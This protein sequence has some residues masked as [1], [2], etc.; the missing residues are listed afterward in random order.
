MRDMAMLP[1]FVRANL[2]SALQNTPTVLEALTASVPLGSPIW[3]I[4]PDPQRF[5]LREVLAHLA[6]WEE[7]FQNRI[8]RIRDE[9]LPKLPD[10]D[11]DEFAQQHHYA[12]SDP[13][14]QRDL[15]AKRRQATV[16]IVKGL[17]NRAW[18]RKGRYMEESPRVKGP[19]TIESWIA[20]MVAHDVYHIRQIMDW[21]VYTQQ[22]RKE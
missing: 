20:Q 18:E 3:D 11:P 22:G 12:A 10:L 6:D 21:L 15:F 9:Y 2:V 1:P 7:V 16:E 5:T 14:R 4:R 19:M 17:P 13:H 8:I